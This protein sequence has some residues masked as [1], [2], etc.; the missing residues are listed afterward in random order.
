MLSSYTVGW[1]A[2]V[3]HHTGDDF[4]HVSLTEDS[5]FPLDGGAN[6]QE[7]YLGVREQS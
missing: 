6:A 4:G 7:Q 1:A 5:T 2:K 3:T